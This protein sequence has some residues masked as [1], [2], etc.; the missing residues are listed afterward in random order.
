MP[1]PEQQA[2]GGVLKRRLLRFYNSRGTL[3]Y[4]LRNVLL[5]VLLWTTRRAYRKLA[6]QVAD[7]IEDYLA[8]GFHVAGIVGVDGSPSCGVSK[9]LD[10]RRSLDLV[11][12]LPADA[13]ADDINAIV[14]AS[15]A[16]GMGQFV[17]QLRKE[18]NR[19]RLNV[20]FLA[21]DLV[22][23]LQGRSTPLKLA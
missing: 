3:R 20:P 7:Q 14:Q 16:D 13:Q 5:P 8:S 2:W 22:A 9:T 19:R 23:E 10:A 6:R 18:L 4:R 12:S 1:C 17:E 21:H 15:L 11:G